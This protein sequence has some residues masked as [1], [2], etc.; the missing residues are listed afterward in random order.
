MFCFHGRLA[1]RWAASHL[2]SYLS[3]QAIE[4][5][6][7]A[8]FTC[9]QPHE[10][11]PFVVTAGSAFSPPQSVQAAFLRFLQLV[12]THNWQDA[13]LIVDVE[14]NLTLALLTQIQ[15]PR[16]LQLFWCV[17]AAVRGAAATLRCCC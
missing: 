10:S 3:E 12:A 17:G 4:L 5:M 16:L 15:V 14:Q 13:P 7:A 8:V 11:S 6:M 2:R 1:K 9:S